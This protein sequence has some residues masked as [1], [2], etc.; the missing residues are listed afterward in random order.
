[1]GPMQ[2][3]GPGGPVVRRMQLGDL[4]VLVDED[5]ELRSAGL[6]WRSS[7]KR[8][9]PVFASSCISASD[10]PRATRQVA[11]HRAATG[12]QQ[13]HQPLRLAQVARTRPMEIVR[14]G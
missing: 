6:I 1:M 10:S 8:G 2:P 5:G 12:L 3:V 11:N 9:R 4:L 14:H 7:P 13:R